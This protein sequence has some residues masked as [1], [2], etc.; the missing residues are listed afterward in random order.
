M[1]VAQEKTDIRQAV[2]SD[3]ERLGFVRYHSWLETYSGLIDADYLAAQS[4]AGSV[5]IFRK[6]ACQ[7]V[8]AATVGGEIVGF[9]GF[10]KYRFDDAAEGCG[11]IHGIYIL[12]QYQRLSLGKRLIREAKAR[13]AA[14]GYHTVLLW[15]LKENRSAVAFY[16]KQGFHF[17]GSEKTA[18]LKTPVVEKRYVCPLCADKTNRLDRIV[19]C[20][21]GK[22][23]FPQS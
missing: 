11:E 2:P 5:A 20:K 17:D 14:L 10:G 15:V 8:I 19:S 22:T 3:A 9:C 1:N 18:T 4:V 12:R 13:L 23:F 7:N 21:K 6:T 16:E